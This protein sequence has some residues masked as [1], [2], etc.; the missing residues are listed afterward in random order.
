[1]NKKRLPDDHVLN[2]LGNIVGLSL[3][4]NNNG[5]C[6]IKRGGYSG[7]EYYQL[8]HGFERIREFVDFGFR[9]AVVVYSVSGDNKDDYY[10]PRDSTKKEIEKALEG[11]T[12]VDF[13]VANKKDKNGGW[14]SMPNFYYYRDIGEIGF[15]PYSKNAIENKH[16]LELQA[17][18]DTLSHSSMYSDYLK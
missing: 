9:V 8:E 18:L 7:A 15:V 4:I 2:R 14:C 6:L 1:M 5:E 11:V 16:P 13:D 3:V 10:D 17:G 12:Y